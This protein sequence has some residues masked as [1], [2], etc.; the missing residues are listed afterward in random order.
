MAR[1]EGYRCEWLTQQQNIASMSDY[2]GEQRRHRNAAAGI[3]RTAAK[4]LQRLKQLL[5]EGASKLPEALKARTAGCNVWSMGAG[6]CPPWQ[7]AVDGGVQPSNSEQ[8][9][10]D[11]LVQKLSMQLK[12]VKRAA[13]ELELVR[14]EM[15]DTLELYVTRLGALRAHLG[16][17]EDELHARRAVQPAQQASGL[18]GLGG[19]NVGEQ[20]SSP[21]VMD[22]LDAWGT[23]QRPALTY[24]P[25]VFATEERTLCGRVAVLHGAVA[26]AEVLLASAMHILPEEVVAASRAANVDL[27]SSGVVSTNAP[28]DADGLFDSDGDCFSIEACEDVSGDESDSEEG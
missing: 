16:T 4:D 10:V 24:T 20:C 13:E 5:A 2:P 6:C 9:S 22:A 19:N 21:G 12:M 18:G 15:C 28:A 3:T 27:P 25:P 7:A 23:L 14:T 17:L 26:A 1:L 8:S 11:A